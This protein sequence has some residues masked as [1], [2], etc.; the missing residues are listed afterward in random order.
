MVVT[1]E[2]LRTI[3]LFSSLSDEQLDAILVGSRTV[4][5]GRHAVLFNERDHGEFLL[6]ILAGQIK[7]SLYG[8]DGKELIL[9]VLGPNAILGE[10]ALLDE[11]ATRSATVSALEKTTVLQCFHED[12]APALRDESFV[13]G[14]NRLANERLRE[15]N[16]QLR[17]M[18]TLDIPDRV[19]LNALKLARFWGRLEGARVVLRPRPKH[20]ILAHMV[21]CERETITRALKDLQEGGFV[22]VT[23]DSLTVEER[24][25]R[26]VGFRP[27]A[28]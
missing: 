7:V 6:V 4:T 3:P 22:T 5:Y 28:G 13:S 27:T 2:F 15:T 1:R 20:E 24:G 19:V 9:A 16:E 17:A 8:R 21:G 12:L 26:R 14:L 23:R 10:M 18:A 11:S 25:I